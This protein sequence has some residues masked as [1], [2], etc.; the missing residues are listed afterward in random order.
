MNLEDIGIRS[1]QYNTFFTAETLLRGKNQ[2]NITIVLT[3]GDLIRI[4]AQTS[5]ISYL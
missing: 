4:K 3:V 1:E 2:G 5:L